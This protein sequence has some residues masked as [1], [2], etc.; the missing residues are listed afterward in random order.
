MTLFNTHFV[1]NVGVEDI[2][3]VYNQRHKQVRV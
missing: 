1:E 2:A 3:T